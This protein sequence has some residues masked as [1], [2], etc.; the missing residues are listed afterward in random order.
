MMN[1][2]LVEEK[3]VDDFVA[4]GQQKQDDGNRIDGVHHPEVEA[5]RSVRVPFS[6]KIHD[7]THYLVRFSARSARLLA[8]FI[9]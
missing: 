9:L 5:G 1:A 8:S 7:D 2:A 6:E 3:P 4:D